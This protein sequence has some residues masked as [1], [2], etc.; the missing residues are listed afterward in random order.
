MSS[1][2]EVILHHHLGL[3]DH[4]ICNGLVHECA[5]KYD[6]IHLPTKRHN[7][8]TVRCLYQEHDNI[9]V[10]PVLRE[11]KDVR[12]YS[13]KNNLPILRIGFEH[14]EHRGSV[15]WNV[16]FYDQMEIPY[17]ARYTSF[18]LPKLLP[19]A[20]KLYDTILQ[21]KKEYCLIHQQSSIGKFFIN[22]ETDLPVIELQPG[23]TNNLLDYVKVI[24]NAQEIHCI[25]SSVINLI[26]SM[27]TETDK[28]F[29]HTAKPA[30]V[31]LSDRWKVVK[32]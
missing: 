25:D 28:L 23:L 29:F 31:M 11:H 22:L 19:E 1:N 16:W 14:M 6:K 24:R 18:Q 9:A 26:D 8:E 4:F 27:D 32:Y 13:I 7:L 10:F 30:N 12:Q 2:K 17:D 15:P 3:G 20:E 21:G 5:K